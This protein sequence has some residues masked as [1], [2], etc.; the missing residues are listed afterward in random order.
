[1]G[2]GKEEHLVLCFESLLLLFMQP[3]TMCLQY[4]TYIMDA[5]QF[6]VTLQDVLES[7]IQ[8]RIYDEEDVAE[9]NLASAVL[10]RWAANKIAKF[11]KQRVRRS[12]SVGRAV[13]SDNTSS[14]VSQDIGGCAKDKSQESAVNEKSP[15][16][17][18]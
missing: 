16:L 15:L 8:E 9:R 11:V 14:N 6:K 10:T 1:M 5:F 2:I 7:V 13:T 12:N 18:R 17:K 3:G 4:I